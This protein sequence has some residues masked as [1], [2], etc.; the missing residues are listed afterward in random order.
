MTGEGVE[1]HGRIGVEMLYASGLSSFCWTQDHVGCRHDILTCEQP[2]GFGTHPCECAEAFVQLALNTQ[3]TSFLE[4]A[5]NFLTC[6][7]IPQCSH[8]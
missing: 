4:H 1:M 3:S 6:C 5:T 2:P 7:E 8:N